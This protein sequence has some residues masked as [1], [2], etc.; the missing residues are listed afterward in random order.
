MIIGNH[1]E[2]TISLSRFNAHWMGNPKLKILTKDSINHE[3]IIQY[4]LIVYNNEKEPTILPEDG[5]FFVL[6]KLTYKK[7]NDDDHKWLISAP[8]IINIY[9]IIFDRPAKLK[10]ID[11]FINVD[12]VHD[13]YISL[14]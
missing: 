9:Q 3:D 13:I 11:I 10:I 6:I 14:K 4:T 12:I 2:E 8:H 5:K 1:K 7:I